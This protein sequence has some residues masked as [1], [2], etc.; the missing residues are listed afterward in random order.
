MLTAVGI[1]VD[2]DAYIDRHGDIEVNA[3][4]LA[5]ILRENYSF[6]SELENES[7]SA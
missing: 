4:D 5:R 1:R 6:E 2:E 3:A 7:K